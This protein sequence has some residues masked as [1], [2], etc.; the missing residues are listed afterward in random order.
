MYKVYKVFILCLKHL[1]THIAFMWVFMWLCW[2]TVMA[3]VDGEKHNV[4]CSCF[5]ALSVLVT[6]ESA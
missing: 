6:F 3:T 4:F 2:I 5:G 1:G